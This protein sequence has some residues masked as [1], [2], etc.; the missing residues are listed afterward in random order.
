MKKHVMQSRIGV[1]AMRI[2]MSD[3]PDEVMRM[4]P[5]DV[6]D[7]VIKAGQGDLLRAFLAQFVLGYDSVEKKFYSLDYGVEWLKWQQLRR[8]R[9]LEREGDLE[10]WE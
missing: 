8:D 2:G 4:E 10:L 9:S 7:A 5:T 3:D 1:L 6:A